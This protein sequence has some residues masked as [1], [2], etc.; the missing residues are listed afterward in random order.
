MG[1]CRCTNASP[2]SNISLRKFLL[3]SSKSQP[4]SNGIHKF[5]SDCTLAILHLIDVSMLSIYDVRMLTLRR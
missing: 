4:A 1:D 2:L 5:S 3:L